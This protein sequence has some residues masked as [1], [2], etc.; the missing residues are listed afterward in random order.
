[1]IATIQKLGFA[2]VLIFTVFTFTACNNHD[3]E[4]V[5][6]NSKFYIDSLVKQSNL[7]P[8]SVIPVENT[9]IFIGKISM[10]ENKSSRILPLAGGIVI[11]VAADLGD[12]VEKGQ[13]LATI[14]S[15]ELIDAQKDFKNDESE[16]LNQEKNVEAASSLY[17]GGL[18][19]EKDF[20]LAKN[21]LQVAKNNLEKSKE[22]LSIYHQSSNPDEFNI[23][24]PLSGY[25]IEKNIS[26]NSQFQSSQSESLFTVSDL[27]DVYADA[28][29]YET[30]IDKIKI[31]DSVSITTLAYPDKI[32][33][34]IISKVFNVLD[35]QTKTMKIRVRLN[36]NIYLKPEMF[37]Q[38]SMNYKSGTKMKA[39]PKEAVVFDNS[40]NYIVVKQ[41][42]SVVIKK[43]DI[44]SGNNKY[45]YFNE[46]DVKV[47]DKVVS[48][49]AL[50]IYNAL[51]D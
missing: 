42:D 44:V 12:K 22:L 37:A 13:L 11:K 27:N 14:K 33:K 8:V 1:M 5:S 7:Y 9:L 34:G 47:N 20:L 15:P 4:E 23:Y 26:P 28:N 48:K 17:K 51:R 16:L 30:D 45:V 36:N 32:F 24:A 43:I 21:Q 41:A 10:D 49:D 18:L 29:V 46:D 40:V 2:A 6:N 19:S 50:L 35:P 25:I 3:S 39:V 31:N 38:I